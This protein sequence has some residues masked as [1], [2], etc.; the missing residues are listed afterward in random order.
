MRASDGRRVSAFFVFRADGENVFGGIGWAGRT[1]FG[2]RADGEAVGGRGGR[3][4][5]G[6][7]ALRLSG[8]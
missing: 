4:I 8:S 2:Y 5:G 1:F 3:G 7:G 6:S